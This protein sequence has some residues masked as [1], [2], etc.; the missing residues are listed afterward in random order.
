[1]I[2]DFPYR[3]YENIAPAEIPD[4]NLMGVYAPRTLDDVDPEDVVARGIA[5]PIGAP[6][7]REAVRRNGRVLILVD[8]ATRA[9]PVAL[10]LR[11]VIEELEAAGVP[12]ERIAVLTALG[13]HR[14]MTERELRDKLGAVRARFIVYQHDWL[15]QATL[16]DFGKTS[17]GTRV[18]ANRLL[19]EVDF[20]L[21]IG[22]IAPHRIK[23]FSGG[24]KIAFPG[25]AG[26][27]I[28]D[29]NQWQAAQHRSEDVMGIAENPMRRRIEEAARLV[30]LHYIVNTVADGAGRLAGCFAGDVVL[31]HRAGCRVSQEINEVVLPTRAGIV[32]T[33]AHPADRDLWQSAK[34][35]Y[36]GTMAVRDGGTLIVVASNPEGVAENHPTM[37]E[38][39]YRPFRELARMVDEGRVDDLV[40][41]SVLADLAQVMDRAECILVSPGVSRDSAVRLGFRPA[42]T[43]QNALDQ[44]R[45]R[46]GRHE[47]IAVLRRGGHVLPR[48]A[49]ERYDA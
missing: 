46:H 45:E 11:H 13:T 27:E 37:L 10:V 24:A 29:R 35:V 43:V 26:R 49:G 31:A 20:T 8:D 1:V 2:V 3:G 9:T 6:R 30:G 4:A 42:A 25:V 44:A 39:G 38:V 19:A 36:S 16:R 15:H 41:L 21:G 33:D 18:T 22:S 40:G 48:V 34:G 23:G 17:D 32:L 28:Q 14:R 47:S 5:E 12:D 7:L